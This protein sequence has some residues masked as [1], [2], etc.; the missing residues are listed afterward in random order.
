MDKTIPLPGSSMYGYSTYK[1]QPLVVK[2]FQWPGWSAGYDP[3]QA[4]K[5]LPAL[6][7][8]RIGLALGQARG[9]RGLPPS[10]L[11][12]I[13][14]VIVIPECWVLEHG[15]GNYEVLT[16][17]QFKEQY[18]KCTFVSADTHEFMTGP[19]E[20][21]STDPE[22]EEAEMSY[23]E[24]MQKASKYVCPTCNNTVDP[25][26]SDWMFEDGI[27]RHYHG[28]RTGWIDTVLRL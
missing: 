22:H 21:D 4:I 9:T 8:L 17:E 10:C 13:D 11:G 24:G 15:D 7:G 14:G 12:Y 1:R 23:E 6:T 25:A 18:Q 26:T 3:L 19:V 16:D 28:Y 2:A 27:W 5:K 20:H